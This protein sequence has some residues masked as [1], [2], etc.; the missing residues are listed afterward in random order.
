MGKKGGKKKKQEPK[1]QE[2]EIPAD[3]KELSVPMLRDRIEA[4]HYRLNKA[5]KER[6]YMQLEKDMVNRFYEITKQEVKQIEAELL[7]MDRQMEMLER[8]HRVHIKVHEQKVQN[9]EYEHK[10]SKRHV[11]QDGEMAIQ[12]E[13]DIHTD[14]VVQMNREKSD[15]KRELKDQQLANEEDV[16]I[17]RQNFDKNLKLLRKTFEQNHRQLESQYEEQVKQL[18]ID[19]E[20]KAK[21]EIHEIEERKNQHINE[22]LF[23][24]Q[25]AFDEI[26][27]YYNDITHD[28]LQLIRDLK[29]EIQGM[30]EREKA[31]QKRMQVLTQENKDLMEPLL[32]KQ[33]EQRELEEKLKSYNKDKMALKNLRAHNKQLEERTSE[34]KQE[35]RGTEEKFRKLEKERDDLFRRFQK[36]VR[37]I[38]R[39]A[40]LGKNAIL[41][42]KLEVL[43]VQ[44]EEKQAQLTEV[45][46][47][48]KL[49][50]SVVASVTKKLEQVLGAKNRQIKDLQYQVHQCTKAY[51]DT[52]LVY[53]SK[54]PSFG[55]DPEE[56]GFEPIQTATSKMPARLVTRVA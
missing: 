53:E 39:R 26:K 28:N 7:N 31:N 42:K 20:L 11:T 44:F 32:K 24:H 56:I 3:L 30:K 1:E 22:L 34:A 48:A 21:V 49:D 54:L 16:K 33:E 4:F 13:R 52:I 45:L 27:T 15:I 38:Q 41:E 43:Q 5:M 8:D 25:E 6:N 10:N 51:N 35:Y 36:A 19:L 17:T 37:E 40:E 23:N 18:K 55:I 50:P 9:L 12:S 2:E 47:A 14:S 29:S 46:A